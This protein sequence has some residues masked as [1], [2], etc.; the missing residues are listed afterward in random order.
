MVT[1]DGYDSIE[2]VL[3]RRGHVIAAMGNVRDLLLPLDRQPP[4]PE[5]TVDQFRQLFGKA[6][7]RKMARL[8]AAGREQ[9][10]SMSQLQAVAGNA[11]SDYAT[12]LASLDLAEV[13]REGM[14]LTRPIDNIGPTLEWYVADLCRRELVGSAEWSVKL[15]EVPSVGGDFDVLAW[16]A[17]TLV[18]VE[19]KS[20]APAQVRDN[21]LRHFLQRGLELAPDIAVLLIDTSDDLTPL[22]DR[23]LEVMLPVMRSASG[24][25]D[26]AWRPE[27]PFIEPQEG[28][29]GVSFGFSRTYVTNSHPSVLTQMRRCLRHYHAHVK[30]QSFWGTTT[31]MRFV[32]RPTGQAEQV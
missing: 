24:I 12:F 21:E 5:E 17:A 32:A 15:E 11:A 6:S 31:G 18:Y 14:R 10:V 27:R 23:L 26:P 25:S 9:P 8:L 30:G 7:F 13:L 16:L 22:L 28:Y 19:L 29:A 3:R 4:P 2:T 1:Y 20:A